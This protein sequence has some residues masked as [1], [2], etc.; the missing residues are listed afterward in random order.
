MPSYVGDSLNGLFDD[1]VDSHYTGAVGLKNFKIEGD[2]CYVTADTYM[3]NVY[4]VNGRVRQKRDRIR[5]YLCRNLTSAMNI[6]FSIKHIQCK[7]CGSSFDATKQRNCPACETRYE[8]EGDD[9]VV[10]RIEKL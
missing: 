9:W 10:L 3:D 2:W 1:I 6:N 5:V 4:D 7:N 8:I